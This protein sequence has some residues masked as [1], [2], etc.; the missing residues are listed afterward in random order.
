MV[1]IDYDGS[2]GTSRNDVLQRLFS[3]QEPRL[4]T[5]KFH[6][7]TQQRCDKLLAR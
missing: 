4:Q 3:R 1:A 2:E 5:S 6:H 7:Q